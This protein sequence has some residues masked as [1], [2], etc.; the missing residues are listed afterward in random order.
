MARTMRKLTYYKTTILLAFA[1]LVLQL[2]SCSSDTDAF[3]TPNTANTPPDVTPEAT[4]E[5]S[6]ED[7]PEATPE[8]PVVITEP[9]ITAFRFSTADNEG[10]TT[11]IIGTLDKDTKTI[12]V[13]LNPYS[14]AIQEL[15]PT[16]ALSSG[17]TVSPE[18]KAVQDFSSEITYTVTAE[19]GTI[20][21]YTIVPSLSGNICKSNLQ[22]S[23]P[24][25][26]SANN[27]RI[28]N[29]YIKTSNQHGIEINNFSGVVISNCIIEYTG[30]YTGI[31]F[32]N[33][34][35]LTINNCSITY[36]N[37]PSSGPLPDATRNCIEGIESQNLVIT[38]VKVK[39]G[40]TGIS[41]NQCD[42]SVL[43]YI[44]GHNMRGPYPRGQFVQYDKCIGGL[45]ENFSVINDRNIAW[46]E[47]NIS[48]Y[49]SA[50]QQIKKGL[51]VGNNSPTGVGVLF[52]DQNTE[53]ARGGFGGLVEDVDFLEM[54]NG[55]V[56]SVEGSKNVIFT[57][58]RAKQI[59][60]GDLGQN[61]GVPT[62]NSLIFAAFGTAE[63]TG[64]NKIVDCIVYNSCN[65]T[66][67]VWPEHNF[68][69]I[70]Y[71]DDIDFEPRKP[72]ELHF[73]CP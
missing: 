67:I 62:S 50:G 1:F 71:R 47:D 73:T 12:H 21:T 19:N 39:D 24:I 51:I 4:P 23:G 37:A 64:A 66:N 16:I 31:K 18:S 11:D 58:I 68:E 5:D 6:P 48:I 17:T 59:I 55:V 52:E 45:L 42:D 26:V 72:I 57:R 69:L 44:E 41:L 20:A 65:P 7:T 53:G 34:D 25:S 22:E 35:N 8:T 56:S 36:T 3:N 13:E 60:C 61:R 63:G 54:G 38:N 46:T 30:A 43:T 40:S 32:A 49:K 33:A 14:V 10:L 70:D 27:Q 15:M 2:G 28:E 9:E 29:L